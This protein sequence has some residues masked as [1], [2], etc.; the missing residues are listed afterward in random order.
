ERSNH[1]QP[2][3][4]GGGI[5]VVFAVVS[6]MMVAGASANLLWAALL[7]AVV[8]FVD[9]VRGLAPQ[10]RLGTQIIAVILAIGVLKGQ[11]WQV[12]RPAWIDMIAAAVLWLWV[13]NLTNFMDGIDGIT[14][15]ETISICAGL[16][17]LT[18]STPHMPKSISIDAGV[19]AAAM[20][21]F[22]FWNWHPARVFL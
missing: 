15:A 7:L 11:V 17:L 18:I 8:S 14:A 3:V 6:F 16:I 2:T 4:R 21:G 9:D 13:T 12:A 1:T 20:M 22:A 10:T 19:I 5:G